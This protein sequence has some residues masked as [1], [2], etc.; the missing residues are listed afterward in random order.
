MNT[1]PHLEPEEQLL[2]K[3]SRSTS[4]SSEAISKLT[5]NYQINW[6]SLLFKARSNAVLPF[7]FKNLPSLN[8]IPLEV[9]D[10]SQKFYYKTLHTNLRLLDNLK[11]ILIKLEAEK[12]P[13]IVLKGPALLN[14]VYDDP[15]IR[16]MSDL[17]LLVTWNDLEKTRKVLIDLGYN[18]EFPYM[19][20]WH[21]KKHFQLRKHL[22]PLYNSA[23]YIEVHWDV[24]PY[25]NSSE[26]YLHEIWNEK[27]KLHGGGFKIET[28]KPEHFI[29]FCT[30]HIESHGKVEDV[31]LRLYTDIAELIYKYGKQLDWKYIIESARENGFHETLVKHLLPVKVYFNAGIPGLLFGELENNEKIKILDEFKRGIAIGKSRN[32]GKIG[33]NELDKF[34]TM[35]EKITGAF[36]FMF[37]SPRYLAYKY[38]VKN[39]KLIWFYYPKR[40]YDSAIIA[41][42][43]STNYL[44]SFFN[45]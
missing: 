12:I 4:P 17:D 38:K 36:F 44:L 7:L 27:V 19:S 11:K 3:I 34:D 16:Q 13:C 2:L 30:I 10:T 22:M 18:N 5:N 32:L 23:A 26:K 42:K 25:P 39:I 29:Q 9:F 21:R 20:K 15:G 31:Q 14:M 8:N 33:T 28:L 41:T 6:G 24:L 37:P 43:I 35:A 40:L 45:K 1:T